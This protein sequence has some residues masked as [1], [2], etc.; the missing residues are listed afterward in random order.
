MQDWLIAVI[1]IAGSAFISGIVGYLVKHAFDKYFKKKEAEDDKKK[2]ADNKL[3]QLEEAELRRQ[4]REDFEEALEPIRLDIKEVKEDI[5]KNNE[6]SLCTLRN[7]ILTCYYRCAEKGYRSD[8]DYT[9][10]H[11]M[12]EAYK[13]LNGNTF[14][15]DVVSRF[16]ALD[17]KEEYEAQKKKASTK[18]KK[19]II[20][21]KK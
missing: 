21:E 10:I 1:S 17:T 12:F 20:N 19:T 9:N 2:E 6:A 18:R 16:D 4:R 13:A 14:V 15:A 3:K 5:K 7:D 8:N 11:D